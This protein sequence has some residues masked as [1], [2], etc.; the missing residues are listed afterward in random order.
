MTAYDADVHAVLEYV[1]RGPKFCI[2]SD[3]VREP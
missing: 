2:T 1:S 3:L